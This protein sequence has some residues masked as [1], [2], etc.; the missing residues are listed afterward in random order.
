ML[1]PATALPCL[2]ALCGMLGGCARAL[3]LLTQLARP[4]QTVVS[5]PGED[6]TRYLAVEGG[7]LST[8]RAL[9]SRWNATA[10]RVC[11]G[12]FQRLGD[13]GSARRAMGVTRSRVHEGYIQCLMPSEVEPGQPG[14]PTM[15]DA[16]PRS[17]PRR[18]EG[19]R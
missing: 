9:R 10:R 2:V 12:E 15:A 14:A 1:R 5:P 8:S 19:R 13:D 11:E 18:R 7:P 16:S 17:A 6:G 4:D 3:P